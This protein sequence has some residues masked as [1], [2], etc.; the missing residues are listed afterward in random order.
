[1]AENAISHEL[2]ERLLREMPERELL[3]LG[4]KNQ[5]E[6]SKELGLKIDGFAAQCG[7]CLLNITDQ[8]K[9]ITKIERDGKWFWLIIAG[10][11]L[12]SLGK[13]ILD[14]LTGKN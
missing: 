14:T 4:L 13:F 5:A 11:F 10:T 9:R 3:I 12:V 2:D 7:Q 1:M 6:T 8:E